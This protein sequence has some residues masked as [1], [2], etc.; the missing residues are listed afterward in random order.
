MTTQFLKTIKTF[1][2]RQ[3]HLSTRQQKAYDAAWPQYALIPD[4]NILSFEKLFENKNDVICEIGFGN[5]DT[6]APM[7]QH[8]P[9]KNYLGIE[10]H[11][12]GIANLFLALQDC[13]ANNLHIIAEDAVSVFEKNI[14]DN[15][16]SR[17]H[18]FFP[19]PWPKKKHRKRRLVNDAFM[20]TL[21]N[22]LKLNGVIH[23]A[24]DWEDYSVQMQQVL[25]AHPQLKLIE[26]DGKSLRATSK[27][28]Q[29]GLKLGHC[30]FDW[31]FAKL[32]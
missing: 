30:V 21:V 16:L 20:I 22:K 23:C 6:L 28:E 32:P 17:I 10:I 27:F 9:D 12:P 19:D 13:N 15:S 29:R 3:R 25:S 2:R 7:V 8:N 4:E 18:I 11:K 24:T 14:P 1:V 31:V 26:I 5:G